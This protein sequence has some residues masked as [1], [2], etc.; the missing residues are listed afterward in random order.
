MKIVERISPYGEKDIEVD[1]LIV[2]DAE[3]FKLDIVRY[4]N[5]Q[6]KKKNMKVILQIKDTE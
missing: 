4:L 2:N 6:R 1:P 5:L 3:L